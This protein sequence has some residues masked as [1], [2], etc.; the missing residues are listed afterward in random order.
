M[1]VE[2]PTSSK[3]DRRLTL[4]FIFR[5]GQRVLPDHDPGIWTMSLLARLKC[6]ALFVDIRGIIVKASGKAVQ[7]LGCGL[8]DKPLTEVLQGWSAKAS[9]LS[10]LQEPSLFRKQ[11]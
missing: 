2:Q 8:E 7:L 3:S 4:F 10:K 1:G 9:T 5:V 11:P 6:V